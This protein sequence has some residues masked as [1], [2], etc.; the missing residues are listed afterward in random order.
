[1]FLYVTTKQF[2]DACEVALC[3]YH[4]CFVSCVA[5]GGSL[6]ISCTETRKKSLSG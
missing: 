1:M 5:S 6:R 4:C 2:V 3:I